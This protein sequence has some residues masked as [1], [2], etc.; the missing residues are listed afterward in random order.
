MM[1]GIKNLYI[2]MKI[3]RNKI[4]SW[5]PL[6]IRFIPEKKKKNWEKEV[7]AWLQG[8]EKDRLKLAGDLETSQVPLE[9]Y[10]ASMESDGTVIAHVEWL[11]E[12]SLSIFEKYIRQKGTNIKK[13][14][15][16]DDVDYE[17]IIEPIALEVEFIEI[18]KKSIQLE[19]G[20][21]INVDS[22]AVSKY[23]ISVGQYD[24]FVKATN[25]KTSSEQQGEEMTYRKNHCFLGMSEMEILSS[26]AF[27]ISYYD[28]VA[29][30]KWAK[31]RLPKEEEWL[32][33]SVL[34]W[35]NQYEDD[36]NTQNMEQKLIAKAKCPRKLGNE[37]VN[38]YDPQ[39]DCAIVRT[40]PKYLLRKNWNRFDNRRT[41]PA[42]YSDFMFQFRVC[43]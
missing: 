13:L 21:V 3:I 36:E 17:D 32:S 2:N 15:I 10:I 14:I 38:E 4:L 24:V 25:Y 37:W 22:F 42:D 31:L 20:K 40:G 5:E 43:K 30:C 33:A 18:P 19:D 16:G 39:R 41:L 26:T 9:Y 28:A 35:E 12:K 1:F 7:F 34:D 29:Y 23:P 8:W 6:E 27:W 11:C